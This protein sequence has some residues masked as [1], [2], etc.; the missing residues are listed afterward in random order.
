MLSVETVGCFGCMDGRAFLI[1]PS[2]QTE[3]LF[4]VGQFWNSH[5][6][7]EVRAD[8]ELGREG[9]CAFWRGVYVTFVSFQ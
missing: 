6:V 3:S 1:P 8:G 4:Q 7:K 2:I 9:G 5:P